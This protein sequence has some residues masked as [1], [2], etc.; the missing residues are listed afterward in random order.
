MLM[1]FN[2]TFVSSNFDFVAS[3][4]S[5]NFD[6]VTS[7]SSWKFCSK[8][9]IHYCICLTNY[10]TSRSNIR[11]WRCTHYCFI[12][13][14]YK[15]KKK[16]NLPNGGKCMAIKIAWYRV[17]FYTELHSEASKWNTNYL[18]S[19]WESFVFSWVKNDMAFPSIIYYVRLNGLQYN[20]IKAITLYNIPQSVHYLQ[21][22]PKILINTYFI[23]G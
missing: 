14:I 7:L 4:V 20:E 9:V 16:S 15:R 22:N 2:A 21:D 17:S 8:E 13:K 1:V 12:T 3:F 18:K 23:L 5:S 6:F 10:T 19:S 11:D